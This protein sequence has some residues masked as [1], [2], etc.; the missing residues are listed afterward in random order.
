MALTTCPD[1]A[2]KISDQAAA[3]IQCGRPMHSTPPPTYNEA[4]LPTA[5]A[6]RV[7][8]Q[9]SRLRTDVGH[10]V[11]F[12]GI[13]VAVVVGMIYGAWTGWVV[14]LVGIGAGLVVSYS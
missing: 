2:A 6:V 4:G 11:A 3:C 9:R 10:A 12:V 5:E 14:A 1:C 8:R 7:G 13:I